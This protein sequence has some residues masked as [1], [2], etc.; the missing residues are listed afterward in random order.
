[1]N[2]LDKRVGFCAN[3]SSGFF[4][5][6]ASVYPNFAKIR[7]Q[8]PFKLGTQIPIIARELPGGRF[9][10]QRERADDRGYQGSA[11]GYFRPGRTGIVDGK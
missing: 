4:R 2:I 9:R 7:A 10:R 1:M 6:R 8:Q 11:Q 5:R 3:R